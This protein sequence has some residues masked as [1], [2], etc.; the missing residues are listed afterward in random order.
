MRLLLSLLLILLLSFNSLAIQK[1]PPGTLI[2]HADHL[3]RGLFAWWYM[4]SGSGSPIVSRGGYRSARATLSGMATPGEAGSGWQPIKGDSN[5]SGRCMELDGTNDYLDC[6]DEL[7][8]T[9]GLYSS[10]S[11]Q[12]RPCTFSAWIWLEDH[13][14][15]FYIISKWATNQREFYFRYGQANDD[16][17]YNQYDQSLATQRYGNLTP[18]GQASNIL[19]AQKWH[20]VVMSFA[21]Q[22]GAG[23][24]AS[25]WKF[26]VDGKAYPSTL[27][28][29]AYNEMENKTGNL[30]I[31]AV[32]GTGSGDGY[33]DD[34]RFYFRSMTEE[35]ARSLSQN[36][37]RPYRE[38]VIRRLG[39]G[40]IAAGVSGSQVIMIH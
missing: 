5:R 1:K 2:N 20:H 12:D 10:A 13:T 28:G 14:T 32:A 39:G 22:G 27:V 37:N 29:G 34:V 8:Y 17:R 23:L 40:I 25:R 15:S 18:T 21:G 31:G 9:R 24:F 3:A 33:I 35:Q 6:G 4:N 7:L 26:Y 16:L 11:D 19:T 30:N 38:N 36:G